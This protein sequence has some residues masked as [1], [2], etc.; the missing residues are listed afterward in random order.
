MREELASVW[1]RSTL[2]NE[3]LVRRLEDWCQRA[4]SS[5][6]APLAQFS[7]RLRRYA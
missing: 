5:G 4:E 6:I 2:T 3:Q 7:L 1:E